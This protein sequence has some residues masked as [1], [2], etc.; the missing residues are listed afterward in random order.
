MTALAPKDW[1]TYE[2]MRIVAK[3]KFNI[4]VIPSHLPA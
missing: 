3:E 2:H 1:Q 4:N